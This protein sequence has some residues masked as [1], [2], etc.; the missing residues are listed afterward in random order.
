VFTDKLVLVVEDDD[1]TRQVLL[2]AID[3]ALGTYIVVAPDGA[4]ALKWI[5]RVR[6]AV[7]VLDLSLP[8]IDGFEVAR[9]VRANPVVAGTG[10]IALSGMAP[11]EE[12][13]QRA[14][15]AGCDHFVPKPFE[16]AELLDLVQRCLSEAG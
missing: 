9:R 15:A 8:T 14:L 13:R 1:A 5:E 3:E 7:V 10:L 11:V 6:P 12:V 4:E 2:S 16:I